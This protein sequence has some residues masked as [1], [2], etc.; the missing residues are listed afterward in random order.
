MPEPKPFKIAVS[1]DLLSFIKQRVD[2]ARLPPGLDLPKGEEWSFGIPPSTISHLQEYWKT[3]YDWRAVEA[4]INGHLKMFTLPISEGGE[5]LTMHFVHHQSTH[6]N[7]IPLLFQHGWPGSFLEVDKIID[8][9]T[10]PSEPG[11][12]AYHVVAPSLPG[13]A[14]SDGPKGGEFNIQNMAAVDHKL[15]LALGYDKY[16]VQGGDWGSMI[17]R[18]MAMDFPESCL[19]IHVNMLGTGPPTWWRYP[20]HMAY[21]VVWA[22]LQGKDSAFQRMLWW[23]REESGYLEIQ[24]TK[25]LTLAYGLVDSPIGTLAWLRDKMEPL[26]GSDFTWGEEEAITWAMVGSQPLN[27][28]SSLTK[29]RCILFLGLL[30]MPR[31]T[32]TQRVRSLRTS[33]SF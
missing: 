31:S 14:F 26:I 10:E 2:T 15:M 32:R 12:Q 3:K 28:P 25:P 24:G 6:S 21:L 20:F 23:H 7:A 30:L 1:D 18:I 9:L 33:K 19:G 29:E 4:R 27:L 22:M 11:Q 8:L 16:I 5:N 17:A 13:F